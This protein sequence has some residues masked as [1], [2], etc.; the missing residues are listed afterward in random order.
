MFNHAEEAAHPNTTTPAPIPVRF[1]VPLQIK[2]EFLVYFPNTYVKKWHIVRA[3]IKTHDSTPIPWSKQ[4]QTV[5]VGLVP[6]T[7]HIKWH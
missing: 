7:E 2:H 1:P 3:C 5:A 6:L 4:H